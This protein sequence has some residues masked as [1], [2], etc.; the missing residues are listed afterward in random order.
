MRPKGAVLLARLRASKTW[1]RNDLLVQ[2][3]YLAHE[4]I[5]YAGHR[6][7]RFGNIF[8]CLS[9]RGIGLGYIGLRSI[10]RV[11]V[12]AKIRDVS[13]QRGFLVGSA[14]LGRRVSELRCA[15]TGLHKWDY[16][17]LRSRSFFYEDI[18][19]AMTNRQ[20]T[21]RQ[22]SCWVR[23]GDTSCRA[24]MCQPAALAQARLRQPIFSLPLRRA[25]GCEEIFWHGPLSERVGLVR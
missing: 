21:A 22:I 19:T 3:P 11:S 16:Y 25:W 9:E 18:T 7:H 2:C 20:C 17:N 12:G 4:V 1:G 13:G 6:L 15:V 5:H 8:R 23:H 14:V 24:G 10:L